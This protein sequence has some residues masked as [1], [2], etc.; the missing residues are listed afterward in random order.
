MDKTT[1][2]NIEKLHP[3]LRLEAINIMCQVDAALNGR[4]TCRIISS[5]RTFKEQEALYA[6]GRTKP[7]KKVTNA[8]PGQS[9][10]NYGLAVDICLIIDG[11][12]ASWDTKADWDGD[13]QSDWMEVV[14]IFKRHGWEW[15]GSWISFKDMPHFQKTF[16]LS[17]KGLL[18]LHNNKTLDEMGYVKVNF[19]KPTNLA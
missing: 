15:G 5:L 3:S 10:H 19:D 8:K 13:K 9:I 1:L 2:A 18:A 11:K 4:A 12:V 17:W 7:G 14:T 16:G 6:Q